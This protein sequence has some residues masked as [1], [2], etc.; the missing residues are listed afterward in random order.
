MIPVPSFA[1]SGRGREGHAVCKKQRGQTP[2]PALSQ[3]KTIAQQ[4]MRK[5]LSTITLLC[6]VTL[7]HAQ[8][9]I[10]H[11]IIFIG[12]A[13]EMDKQQKAVIPDAAGH[14]LPGKTTVVYLGDNI[15]P[16][17]MGLPGS[18]EETQTQQV[19]QSQYKPMR[20]RGAPVYFV[21]GNHDWD[22]SGPAG[23]AKIKRQGDFLHE[24]GDSLLQLLP[25]DGCPDPT[26]IP[27]TD[28]VVII[29]FDSEWWLFPFDK[30]NAGADCNCNTKQDVIA[31]F[32]EILYKNKYKTIFLVDHHPFQ[33]YGTHGGNFS[34][35]DHLFPLTVIKPALYIP[36][37]VIGSLYPFLRGTF[38]N[39]EDLKHPLYQDMVRSIDGV[40][41][42]F[43]NL[44]HVSGHEHGLQLISN[45]ATGQTQIVSGGGAKHNYTIKGKN[46]L[47]GVETQGWVA[48]DLLAGNNIRLTY[49]TYKDDSVKAV[50]SYLWKYQPYKALEEVA[51][52][53]YPADSA[54]VQAHA[55]YNK[56]GWLHRIFLGENY[57]KEWA[58]PARLP[59]IRLSQTAGGL[60]PVKLGGGF[61]S[62]SLRLTDPGGKEY[63]LR[64]VEKK[65]DLVVPQSFQGTFVRE[66]LDDAT[67]AQHPYSSLL[68]PPVAKAAG[69]PHASPVVGVV[70]PDKNMGQYQRLFAGKL[71]LLEEREPLGKSDNTVKMLEELQQDNDN[72]YDAN[73]F[74]RAR[75]VDLL[76]ADWDRHADQWRFYNRNKKGENKYYTG[77]PRDRDMALNLTQGVLPTLLKQFF[78]LAHVRGFA[79]NGLSGSNFYLYKSSFLNAHPASQLGYDEWMRT[80]RQF[81]DAIT[82]TV[83]AASLHALPQAVYPVRHDQLFR[84]LQARRDAMPRA[85]DKYYR[86]VNRIA[87]IHTSDKNEFI[88]LAGTPAGELAVT[89]RKINKN[90]ELKDTLMQKN[91]PASF[92]KE[93]RLYI[94]KGNDSL[95]IRNN[96]P[97]RLRIIGGKGRKAYNVVESSKKIKLY[98]REKEHYYGEVSRI[99]PFLSKDSAH[100]AFVPANLY[101]TYLP[102]LTASINKDDG[103]Y[104]GLGIQYTQQ[105]GFRKTP[106][107]SRQQIMLSHSFSTQAFN[108]LYRGEWLQALKKADFILSANIKA[109][110]NT[111]NFFGRGNE[112]PFDKTGNYKRYYRTRFNIAEFQ[113]A[114]RW[115]GR[116]GA[117]LSIGPALQYYHL[118]ADGNAGRLI[119]NAFLVG[120]Y[121]S[122]TVTKNK[123]HLG[124][125]IDYVLDQ[126]NNKVL[127][128][129]GTYV[130]IQLKGYKGLSNETQSFVQFIPEVAL[131][132]SLNIRQTLVLSNRFGGGVTLGKT[133]FYQSLFLGGQG[134]LLG[135]RQ[136]RF[137]G[138]H[139]L[140]NNLEL[141]VVLSNF[142][143][144]IVKGQIGMGGFYDT[145]RVWEGGERSKK[146]HNGVGGNIYFAPASLAVFRFN[147]AY[148]TEGW[149]PY[150]SVG[151]R[152]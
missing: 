72:S 111:Q 147:M 75:M 131:Y 8:D 81:R 14:I 50:Y 145:G 87:D 27:V 92:T 109:P 85:M 2:A 91:Y 31:S 134:N 121:D 7:L 88:Q 105:G 110:D 144:Y 13:G 17:G 20:D 41:G 37:P 126:R 60:T 22:K 51:Y 139:A 114:L 67:S 133:T 119:K 29:A 43:P 106:Y 128:A 115:R 11:R 122:A 125:V 30:T 138:Q 77:V 38:T 47:F 101:N 127:P 80:A 19:L 58:V 130:S 98:D 84:A 59:V 3:D 90:G 71:S 69:V 56:A 83:L 112:T 46:S 23:L 79:K 100:T 70:A 107:T 78:V 137:A 95:V 26:V 136:Y 53:G 57:R 49:Y 64:T 96:T 66:L 108:M 103:L 97:I 124:A 42:G 5:F 104:L 32:Q 68:V 146:W 73:N 65:P 135:Y 54:T 6:L 113:P 1:A 62:T 44:L 116:K 132:K 52:A 93:I 102:L 61:Q 148:G 82:D 123:T 9:S 143:N 129:W 149:Y 140:Y 118:N 35:K 10:R 45:P 34:W 24:Q 21:P 99:S 55:V 151:L 33:S 18:K 25:A 16:H 152:F 89:I 94:A 150:F 120:S 117:S 28:S 86:F 141:R 74:L 36:L 40:F 76:F 63:T 39:P 48:A 12:D 15:Y 4:L 142:G